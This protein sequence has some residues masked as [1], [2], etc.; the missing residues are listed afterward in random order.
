MTEDL[1]EFME[2]VIG[3][4][5]ANSFEFMCLWREHKEL[6]REFQTSPTGR[7]VIVGH[8]NN[9][10]IVLTLWNVKVEGKKIL[11]WEAVSMV[12]H[13]DMIR[14]WFKNNLPNSAMKNGY[15]NSVDAMNFYN[16]LR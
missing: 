2:G 4:V 3:I 10:P 16:V 6:G 12:V 9:M 13:H 11:I 7:S 1:K 8:F 14:E 5:E 15:V